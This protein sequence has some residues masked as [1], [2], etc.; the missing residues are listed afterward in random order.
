MTGAVLTKNNQLT[1]K[2]QKVCDLIVKGWSNKE[3]A[4]SLGVSR[5]T[6]ENHR[7]AVFNKTGARN[8]VELVRMVLGATQ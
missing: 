3:I 5:R 4:D 7:E 8:A 6:V 1:T 2:Q